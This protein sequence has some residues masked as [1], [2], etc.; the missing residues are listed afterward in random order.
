VGKARAHGEALGLRKST[1]YRHLIERD[2]PARIHVVVAAPAD[3]LE[4]VTWWFPIVGRVAYRGYFDVE[5]AIR[6]QQQLLQRGLDTYVRPAILYST[7]G[8]F[9]DPIPRELLRLDASEIVD[10]ILHE[11]VHETIYTSG[12]TT[13]NEGLATFIAQY[14]T[15]GYFAEEPALRE[16]A[17]RRY[18]DEQ[19]FARLIS[20][21][22]REL[23]V[24][25]Q[26][27]RN[28]EEARRSRKV[29][30]RRYQEEVHP[31]LSWQTKRYQGF[32]K[33]EL[34]NAY[35]LANQTYLGDIPCFEA[36]LREL[37][38]N[39]GAFIAKHRKKPG[40][41]TPADHCTIGE[42]R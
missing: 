15:L 31:S 37:G 12:D 40:R 3:R 17:Q 26:E 25:Y 34:S 35:V 14:A 21:L 28:A 32:P 19:L 36:E 10:T 6:F 1:S 29:V 11:L 13:Y 30:F 33:G 23:E 41:H 27:T 8:W 9:D 42:S 5:R 16:A 38:G 4:P 20:D 39:L 18:A 7:L 24:L 22:T 2:E